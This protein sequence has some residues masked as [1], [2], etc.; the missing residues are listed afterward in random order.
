MKFLKFLFTLFCILCIGDQTLVAQSSDYY[1]IF[2][3]DNLGEYTAERAKE[4]TERT[5]IIILLQENP[6]I[7]KRF[8]N[9]KNTKKLETYKNTI[10]E[11]N[12]KMRLIG[13]SLWH[14]HQS[15]KYMGWGDA[16][17]INAKDKSKYAYIAVLR[18][19]DDDDAQ[20]EDVPSKL[21]IDYDASLIG[22]IQ[23]D[24]IEKST[25][26]ECSVMQFSLLERLEY[27]GGLTVPMNHLIPDEADLAFGF[28]Y[29]TWFIKNKLTDIS[30]KDLYHSLQE[31][32]KELAELTLLISE[33]DAKDEKL[34]GTNNG[35]KK[36]YPFKTQIVT[37]EQLLEHVLAKTP[38]YAWLNFNHGCPGVFS[39]ESR[40]LLF[41]QIPN[42]Y[43]LGSMFE[44]N[45][46]AR[47]GVAIQKYIEQ[48]KEE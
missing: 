31:N 48:S 13:D 14:M 26:S 10:K 17:E 6:N 21:S 43:G 3:P 11:F 8:V 16:L 46:V 12:K 19:E 2:P 25:H 47:M 5:L 44:I 29:I 33:E 15:V 27:R 32:G 4:F 28:N 18:Y 45:S 38:G 23:Y 34:M 40:N 39:T 30:D 1:G 7:I 41:V 20:F 42:A 9:D 24:T 36:P 37:K 35:N 22:G